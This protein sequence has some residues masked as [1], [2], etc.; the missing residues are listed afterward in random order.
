[1]TIDSVVDE[2]AEYLEATPASRRVVVGHSLGGTIAS[3]LANRHPTLVDGLVLVDPSYGADDDEMT[4][5]PSRLDDYRRNGGARSA[6]EIAGAFAS[7]VAPELYLRAAHDVAST[8]RHV[9]ASLFASNYLG[10]NAV[11]PRR[12]AMR[13]VQARTTPTIAFYP[14]EQR[15]EVDK[16]GGAS[17]DVL[18][19][20]HCGHFL[21]AEAPS[22]FIEAVVNWWARQ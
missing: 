21:H 6:S 19:F 20:P 9:L 15:A 4:T 5:V 12:S 3:V 22:E 7:P 18:I 17:T 16:I 10:E 8:D 14:S 11:G 2:L 1:M 13:H